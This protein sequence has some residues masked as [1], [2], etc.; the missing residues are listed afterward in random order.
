VS[1]AETGHHLAWCP[2]DPTEAES[3]PGCGTTHGMQRI[4]GTAPTVDAAM[5]TACGLH[6][7]CTVANPALSIVSLLPTPALRTAALLAVL[8][9]E[10]S[11]GGGPATSVVDGVVEVGVAG[12][13]AAAGVHADPVADLGVAA[14]HCSGEPGDRVLRCAPWVS[15]TRSVA[16]WVARSAI[17]AAHS[18]Q[19]AGCAASSVSR[20]AGI[21]SYT[22][23]PRPGGRASPA[24]GDLVPAAP[25]SLR[26]AAQHYPHYPQQ[27]GYRPRCCRMWHGLAGRR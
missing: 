13:A 22:I 27:Q 8:R 26:R 1:T 9:T 10:V 3:C 16:C 15:W 19:A 24:A 23:P 21:C 20:A 11:L 7:A 18:P 2:T 6:W 12:R 4:T 14:Q 25:A 5:C 17:T